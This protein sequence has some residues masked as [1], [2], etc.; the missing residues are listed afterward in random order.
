MKQLIAPASITVNAK[1][2]TPAVRVIGG[3]LRTAKETDF[4]EL[5]H[6]LS[7]RV[8]VLANRE[9]RKI[10]AG[11]AEVDP[12]RKQLLNE[13]IDSTQRLCKDTSEPQAPST[14]AQLRQNLAKLHDL[15]APRAADFAGNPDDPEGDTPP[16]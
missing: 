3:K 15:I 11:T 2:S 9:L 14:L 7:T 5:V 12:G 4:V 8:M 13:V 16:G 10:E 1:V 6:S